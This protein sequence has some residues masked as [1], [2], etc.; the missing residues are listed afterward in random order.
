MS[1]IK[2]AS[3]YC[4]C[5]SRR[6]FC[7]LARERHA[8]SLLFFSLLGIFIYSIDENRILNYLR[9]DYRC[10]RIA[11]LHC[12]NFRWQLSYNLIHCAAC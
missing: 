5:M 10:E 4:H 6:S 8:V 11:L 2:Y 3:F 9:M 7:D 1:V 12:N